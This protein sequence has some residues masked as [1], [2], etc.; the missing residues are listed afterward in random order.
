MVKRTCYFTIPL[1]YGVLCGSIAYF[2]VR[3]AFESPRWNL[4]SIL[5]LSFS[6]L[7]AIIYACY[8]IRSRILQAIPVE[9]EFFSTGIEN[10]PMLNRTE[11]DRLTREFETLGFR[12][13]L[14][15][16]TSTDFSKTG[17]MAR[18]MAHAE[19]RCVVEINQLFQKTK[20][21]PMGCV[22]FSFFEKDVV[23]STTNRV[24]NG[25][26]YAMRRPQTFLKSIPEATSSQLFETH[27]QGVIK[28]KETH[29]LSPRADMSSES[30]LVGQYNAHVERRE[31][32]RRKNPLVYLIEVDLYNLF[33]RRDWNGR[34]PS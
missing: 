20:V 19:Q 33:P 8:H 32:L 26:S 17:G 31:I 4:F 23:L 5:F 13:L 21:F 34:V 22:I 1:F 15:Y 7:F 18:L 3:I 2:I 28:L 14:D 24:M 29:Q 6:A 25:I 11:F 10:F 9:L 12:F 30:Y 16:T 27:K